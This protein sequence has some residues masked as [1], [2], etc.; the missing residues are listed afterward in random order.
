MVEPRYIQDFP[1]KGVNFIDISPVLA[2]SSTFDNIIEEMCKKV[3][4]DVDYIISP[5]SRGYIFGPTIATRLGKGFVPIRK[6]GKL[7]DDLVISVEYEKEYGKDILCLPKN[8]N[9]ENKNFYF[10]DDVLATAGTLKASKVLIKKARRKLLSEALFI[11][12][13]P[14]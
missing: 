5:E 9:Y 3:P 6:P 7:P 4:E 8:D 2:D 1:I 13:Y 11:L 12:I 14:S 10:V